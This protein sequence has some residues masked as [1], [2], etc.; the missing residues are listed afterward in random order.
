MMSKEKQI[1]V[2]EALQSGRYKLVDDVLHSKVGGEWR[3]RKPCIQPN[4]YRQFSLYN[5]RGWGVVHVYEH[6]LVYIWHNGVYGDFEID[7]IDSD[8][9][10]NK[11]S[12]LKAV[13]PA[14]NVRRSY[15]NKPGYRGSTGKQKTS[16]Q[17][18]VAMDAYLKHGS[19]IKAA[20]ESELS[21]V[22]ISRM[23]K[24]IM[25][26]ECRNFDYPKQ[27]RYRARLRKFIYNNSK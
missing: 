15:V 22:T 5:G 3:V 14:E 26:L 13:T 21:R 19:M 8:P 6:I 16:Y 18:M 4:G 25:K 2:H 12:N 1:R 7:H 9:S 24:Q 11:I 27:V 20:E 23:I 17:I 10:N